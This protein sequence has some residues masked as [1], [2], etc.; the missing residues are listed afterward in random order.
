VCLAGRLELPDGRDLAWTEFGCAGGSPLVAFHG[1]LVSGRYFA[2]Q[3]EAAKRRGVRLIAVDRPGYGDSSWHRAQTYAAS[4]ADTC[5]LADHLGLGRFAVLGQSSGAP[6][7]AGCAA[8]L[9]DRVAACA[10]VSGPAPPEGGVS[11]RQQSRGFRMARRAALAA[12]AL[13]AAVFQTALRQGRR[14]PDKALRHMVQTLP[15][16]DGA[17]LERTDVRRAVRAEISRPKSATEG[18]AATLDLRLQL[19]PWGYR[20][21]DI[22]IP[23]HV[24]HG[25]LD[26]AVVVDEGR[27]VAARIPGSTLHELPDAGHWL[28]H[29]H[30]ADIVDRV[31]MDAGPT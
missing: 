19:R 30:F 15:A 3:D 25:E 6:F 21:E 23:V 1:S 18:R 22:S 29:S 16:C 27:Y 20:I 28:L 7:A 24:W 8:L 2:A 31:V 10:L 11:N 12:P 9:D 13:L 4:A 5:R 14:A 26:R 17:V